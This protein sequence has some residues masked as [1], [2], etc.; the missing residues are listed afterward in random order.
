MTLADHVKTESYVVTNLKPGAVYLFMVRANN[1]YGLSDPSPIS[2]SVRTQG[3]CR[4]A[5]FTSFRSRHLKLHYYF[6]C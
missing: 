4:V 1:A 3:R 2:D 6:T 5:I